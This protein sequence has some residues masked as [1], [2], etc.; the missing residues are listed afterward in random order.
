MG[1]YSITLSISSYFALLDLGMHNVIIRYVSKYRN[2]NNVENQEKYSGI[3]FAF[4]L[5]VSFVIALLSILLYFTIPVLFQKSLVESEIELLLSLFVIM[6]ANSIVMM[7]F[8]MFSGVLKAYEKFVYF[9]GAQLVFAIIRGAFIIILIKLGFNVIA[10]AILDLI[11][12]LIT[13][14]INA[15]Y[16][17]VVVKIKP[18]FKDIKK[19]EVGEVCS[20]SIFIFLDMIAVQLFWASDNIILGIMTTVA[21]VAIYSQGTTINAHF[22]TFARGFSEFFMPSAV[23]MVEG[24]ASRKE[25]AEE[26]ARIGRL[27]IY[28][29]LLILLGFTLIGKQF[30]ILWLGPDYTIAYY[31]ALLVMIPQL[32]TF[33]QS[34]GANIMWAKNKHKKRAAPML[35]IALLNCVISIVLVRY[36]GI[37]GAAIGTSVAYIL[38]YVIYSS[39][40]YDKHVGIDMKLFYKKVFDGILLPL[41][42]TIIVSV[43][44]VVFVPLYS[45]T[46]LAVNALLITIVYSVIMY[47][48]AMKSEEK[49]IIK[50]M[51]GIAGFKNR[52]K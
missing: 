17:L 28:F 18:R 20:Y 42:L 51:L 37:I 24:K 27:M 15:F 34:Y 2:E 5:V 26:M 7:L 30:I 32:I 10:I 14:A 13:G 45:W 39:W 49:R 6:S 16:V 3:V 43:V 23:R 38:G 50:N 21:S 41:A 33:I 31:I 25:L 47:F 52:N 12:N 11:V 36:F 22:Q 44:I 48:F 46:T 29:L 19:S 40:Y 9:K 35:L 8:N 1:V 4:Y